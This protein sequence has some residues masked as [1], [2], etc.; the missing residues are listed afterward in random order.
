MFEVQT[1]II[2]ITIHYF[3]NK[4]HYFY[5]PNYIHK[6][7]LNDVLL[8]GSIN[9]LRNVLLVRNIAIKIWSQ[10]FIKSPSHFP[11]CAKSILVG[12]L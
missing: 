3:F 9:K 6:Y 5:Q 10:S 8:H 12:F 2:Y 4:I 1:L 11:L 7:Y